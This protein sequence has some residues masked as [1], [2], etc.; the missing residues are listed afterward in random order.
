MN[1]EMSKEEIKDIIQSFHNQGYSDYELN[2]YNKS[3]Y[4]N[5]W[6]GEKIISTLRKAFSYGFHGFHFIPLQYEPIIQSILENYLGSNHFI[7]YRQCTK[8][9]FIVLQPNYRKLGI[10]PITALKESYQTNKNLHALQEDEKYASFC[11]EE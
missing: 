6:S 3:D 1:K 8:H 11:Y 7:A 9:D 10:S 4:K 5:K 2:L